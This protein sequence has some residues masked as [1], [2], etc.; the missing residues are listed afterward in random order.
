MSGRG[1]HEAGLAAEDAV[2]RHFCRDG[3]RLAARRWRSMAGEIDL[4]MRDG[5]GVV[6]VEVKQARTH[7]RAAGR[8]SARQRERI[9]LSAEIF[10]EGEPEGQFT[11]ARYELAVV[12]ALGR[13]ALVPQAFA[14]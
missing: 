3:L 7:D 4:V 10:L 11:P 1:S 12:D 6:F 14:A 5:R 13:V 9:F 2:V 8:L